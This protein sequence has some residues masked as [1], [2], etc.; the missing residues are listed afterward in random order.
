M[1]FQVCEI[2]GQGRGLIATEIIQKG[3]EIFRECPIVAKVNGNPDE[4]TCIYIF[5]FYEYFQAKEYVSKNLVEISRAARIAG[6]LQ[7]IKITTQMFYSSM[8][9]R[10]NALSNTWKNLE[11]LLN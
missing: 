7:K 2:D 1:K 3:E 5:N 4:G 6:N 11:I 8:S 9:A 10:E